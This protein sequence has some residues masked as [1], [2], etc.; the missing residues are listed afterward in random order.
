MS[1]KRRSSGSA[2]NWSRKTANDSPVLLTTAVSMLRHVFRGARIDLARRSEH[3]LGGAENRR[4]H[5]AANLFK[6]TF[7]GAD[8]AG[9]HNAFPGGWILRAQLRMA[10][11][12]HRQRARRLCLPAGGIAGS[13]SLGSCAAER[14]FVGGENRAVYAGLSQQR[15][16]SQR[17]EE[18]TSELQ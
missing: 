1:W 16:S 9:G 10:G 18:H 2:K 14:I 15:K 6:P 12:G 11:A 13:G 3:C 5:E 8:G 4:H 7:R 17:S